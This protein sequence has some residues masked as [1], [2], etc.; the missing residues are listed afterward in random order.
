[1]AACGALVTPSSWFIA[2]ALL[3]RPHVVEGT[4]DLGVVSLL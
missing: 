2:G 4:R 1:M 3:F